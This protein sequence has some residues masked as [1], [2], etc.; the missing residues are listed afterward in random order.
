MG[1][2]IES[3]ALVISAA[4]RGSHF[5]CACTH[6][7]GENAPLGRINNEGCAGLESMS[8]QF[9]IISGSRAEARALAPSNSI[10]RRAI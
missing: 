1:I 3:F 6:F 10:S 5:E 4:G 7:D 2:I 9:I 8:V